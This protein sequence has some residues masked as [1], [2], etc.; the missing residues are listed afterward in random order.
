[1]K[2]RWG[3]QETRLDPDGIPTSARNL[4]RIDATSASTAGSAAELIVGGPLP[5]A[6]S[7]VQPPPGACFVAGSLMM[8]G[9]GGRD[10]QPAVQIGCDGE[11]PIMVPQP[12]IHPQPGPDGEARQQAI[13]PARQPS[14]WPRSEGSGRPPRRRTSLHGLPY[15]GNPVGIR[16]PCQSSRDSSSPSSAISRSPKARSRSTAAADTSH[17]RAS[18]CLISA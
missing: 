2:P 11:D 9:L 1:M 10:D 6:R 15:Q 13:S 12:Q 17:R 8:Q 3:Y 18:A 5:L 7:T 4:E 16:L 14:V